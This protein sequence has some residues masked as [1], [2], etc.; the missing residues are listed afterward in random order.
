MPKFFLTRDMV[1]AMLLMG[2]VMAVGGVYLFS[3][4]NQIDYHKALSISLTSLAVFQWF[5]GFNSQFPSASV[6]SR[7]VFRNGYLWLALAANFVLQLLALYHPALQK[8]LKTVPLN[9]SEWVAILGVGF[10]IILVEEIRKALVRL[11]NTRKISKVQ[12]IQA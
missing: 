8:L 3:L 2:A 4:Y 6:F 5:N 9:F 11:V 1:F 7:Q 12:S 10:G